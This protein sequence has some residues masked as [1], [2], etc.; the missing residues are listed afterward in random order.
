M[1]TESGRHEAALRVAMVVRSLPFH[2]TGGM[3]NHAW[4]LACGLAQRGV[5]VHLVTTSAQP[6]AAVPQAPAGV[7]VHFLTGTK[8]G[9]YNAAFFRKLPRALARLHHLKS[10]SLVHA[11]G[12]AGMFL[13][14]L[15]GDLPLVTTIHGTMT[16]ETALSP[17]YF[18]KLNLLEKAAALWRYKHRIAV[19]RSYRRLLRRSALLLVDSEFTRQRLAQENPD[20]APK[21]RVAPLGVNVERYPEPPAKNDAR[22]RL[23]ILEEGAVL[24][25]L[26]RLERTKGFRIAL[27]AI[28]K[29]SHG[30]NFHWYVGGEGPDRRVLEDMIVRLNLASRV[31]LLGRVS[32]EKVPLYYAAADLALVPE[33][34]EPAFGLVALEA[35]LAGAPVLASKIGALPEVVGQH[36]GWLVEPGDSK[37]LT[38]L[39][40]RILSNPRELIQKSVNARELA[41]SKF[42]F[43][44]MIDAT[45]QA[46]HEALRH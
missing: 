17:A 7:F 24:F 6:G 9:R 4:D 33:L 29:C 14:K 27:E 41:L 40:E 22:K 35:M 23:G 11:Q 12:F 20:V 5:E 1:N 39:L 43:S 32:D 18:P 37:A 15:P 13:R 26:G 25:S 31:S 46:Y 28:G 2:R 30:L 45:L 21:V 42:P 36:D 8:P 10:L 44:G 34:V 19:G 16:S 3:E 38:E